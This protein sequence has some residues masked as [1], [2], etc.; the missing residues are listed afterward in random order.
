M[1][2]STA[3]ASVINA[4]ALIVLANY[5]KS[6][7]YG[8]FSVILAFAMIMSFFTD[9][10]LSQVI[11][12]EG[13]K[14][15]ANLST[16]IS[17]YIKMRLGLLIGTLLVGFLCL[18]YFYSN[19]TN[20]IF[21]AYCL[22]IP[23]VAGVGMQSIGIAFFQLREQMHMNA[24][25]RI[26]SSILLVLGI[27]LGMFLTVSPPLI[28]FLYGFSYFAA[29]IVSFG[30][31]IKEIKLD[32]KTRFHKGLFNQLGFFSAA[33]LLFVIGPQLGPIILEKTLSLKEVGIYA[34]AYRIPQALQQI[35]F[36]VAGAFYP[37][38]FR[39]YNNNQMKE[40]LALTILQI[41]LMA[42][43]GMSMMI[44][45]YYIADFIIDVVFGELWMDAAGPLK[46]L[47][48]ILAF[49]AVNIA[50]A[51]GLTT[52]GLQSK[53]TFVQAVSITIGIVFYI[54]LS[55]EYGIIG[56][57][58]AGVLIEIIS[59]VGYWLF[60]PDRNS[61]AIKS[62]VPYLFFILIS[63]SIIEG[64]L[65]SSPIKAILAQ[66][67]ALLLFFLCDKELKTKLVNLKK[68][69]VKKSKGAENGL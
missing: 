4:I 18:H 45:F 8:M 57:A 52:R 13:S 23:M 1:F 10:G 6:Y 39:Y 20:L 51:D 24:L 62:L 56:A 12:R 65:S 30:L 15:G 40:Q 16:I 44:P 46:I 27:V 33:G 5:L 9:A 49:Q 53:R 67:A 19:Q 43:I 55:A 34:V 61:I 42:L 60:I 48:F 59:L 50:L 37:V 14:Q 36:I 2:Y 54:F 7:H 26:L 25:I 3:F 29:G 41:K 66:F 68:W 63:I 11:I 22:I 47:S 64:F 69:N 28:C 58:Y 17:S 31:V 38:L 21:S 35:P 32:F